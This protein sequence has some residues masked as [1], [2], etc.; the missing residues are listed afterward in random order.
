MY[1]GRREK[2]SLELS[3]AKGGWEKARKAG[4]EPLA[5]VPEGWGRGPR[6]YLR[7]H[8]A[9]FA[10]V[11]G[12]ELV[13]KQVYLGAAG[14]A[15]IRAQGAEPGGQAAEPTTLLE[16]WFPRRLSRR[17]AQQRTRDLH[18]RHLSYVRQQGT[19]SGASLVSAR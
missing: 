11:L 1:R 4:R 9:A 18:R 12:N 19:T 16:G 8:A 6:A 13:E 5:K 3:T 15:V 14:A 7:G 2:M 10:V 17:S